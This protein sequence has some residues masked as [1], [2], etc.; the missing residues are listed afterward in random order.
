MTTG[1]V[2]TP[3]M[4]ADRW[5]RFTAERDPAIRE[6]LVLQYAP[7]VKYVAG[8][9]AIMLPRVMDSDDVISSGVLGLIEVIDRYDP[10]TGVTVSTD[11]YRVPTGMRRFL[12]ARDQHCRF[13]GCR[14]PVHRCDIDHT[15][16]HAKGG[17]TRVD[18]LAEL[19]SVAQE[20]VKE[21]PTVRLA[22][23]MHQVERN[24]QQ[25]RKQRDELI[26]KGAPKDRIK[27]IE[28]RIT[29]QMK[30]LNEKVDQVE[31]QKR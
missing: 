25:L 12:Q 29:L 11:S 15:W 3:E 13:P 16:D 23:A 6:Q 27:A 14:Q 2:R 5:V 24:V 7:L 26:K 1:M 21:N 19:E 28:N 10:T 30:T 20:F 4:V 8:R 31:K 22:D 17:P 9:L 18:N